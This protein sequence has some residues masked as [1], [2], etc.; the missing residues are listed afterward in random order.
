MPDRPVRQAKT[1]AHTGENQQ[2]RRV[3]GPGATLDPATNVC[4]CLICEKEGLLARHPVRNPC[5]PVE[6][7]ATDPP[8]LT[9]AL[10]LEVRRAESNNFQPSSEVFRSRSLFPGPAEEDSN[11]HIAEMFVSGCHFRLQV[12][13]TD[14]API[15]RRCIWLCSRRL[16]LLR[17]L[18]SSQLSLSLRF[19]N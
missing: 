13:K 15:Y 7:S 2:Q 1:G 16:L 18:A 14:P 9:P 6:G 11:K 3:R 4:L 12:A 8:G 5:C 19:W 10:S 17:F